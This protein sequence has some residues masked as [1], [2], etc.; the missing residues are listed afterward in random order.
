MTLVGLPQLAKVLNLTPQRV[1]QLVAQ[2]GMPRASRGKYDLGLAMQWY[3]RYLQK[4]LQSR[5]IDTDGSV[6]NLMTQRTRQARETAER[7]EM[8]NL[9]ARGEVMLT[10]EFEEKAHRAVE[11]LT[12]SLAPVAA[13]ATDDPAVQQK[14]EDEHRR[15]RD[16][17]AEN[18]TVIGRKPT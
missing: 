18:L 12:K 9:K 11:F 16:R 7:M 2:E 13:R 8:A 4:A 10:T 3:I 17:F 15:A 6:T 1:N 5:S 14:I